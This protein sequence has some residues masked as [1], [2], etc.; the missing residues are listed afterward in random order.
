MAGDGIAGLPDRPLNNAEVDVLNQH[1][2]ID[3][4]I[5][6][7]ALESADDSA[8]IV[9]LLLFKQG[10][11]YS[12]LYNPDEQAWEQ[13]QTATVPDSVTD[14]LDFDPDDLDENLLAYYELDDLEP[15]GFPNDPLQGLVQKFPAEP[16]SESHLADIRGQPMIEGVIPVVSRA[17][18]G[19][20]IVVLLIFEHPVELQRIVASVGYDRSISEWQVFDSIE[21]SDSDREAAL[22]ELEL[23]VAAWVDDRYSMDE[24]TIN[25][26]PEENLQR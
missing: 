5:P 13:T 21:G 10:T 14:E 4:C 19:R 22:T 8:D 16:L 26:S 11:A 18:D 3:G 23:S 24:I 25:E 7:Y 20:T 9:M 2:D 1:A 12:L 6:V 15:L 17:S